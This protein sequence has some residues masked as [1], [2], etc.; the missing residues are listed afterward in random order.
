[1]IEPKEVIVKHVRMRRVRSLGW[2]LNQIGKD[3]N[4]LLAVKFRSERPK[5]CG[6]IGYCSGG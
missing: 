6:E 1:M 2:F 3:V 5:D 4:T